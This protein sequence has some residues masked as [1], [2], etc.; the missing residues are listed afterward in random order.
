MPILVHSVP[1][2]VKKFTKNDIDIS[3]KYINPE[4]YPG[5]YDPSELPKNLKFISRQLID[6]NDFLIDDE[7][8]MNKSVPAHARHGKTNITNQ[9]GRSNS[10]GVYAENVHYSLRTFGY[11]LD[12]IPMSI[13]VWV[14][15]SRKNKCAND[16]TMIL[17]LVIGIYHSLVHEMPREATPQ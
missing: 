11:K 2:S 1:M 12:N 13:A 3:K 10:R 9:T 14:D 4:V 6:I 7:E 16:S 8:A 15:G 17:N 5:L